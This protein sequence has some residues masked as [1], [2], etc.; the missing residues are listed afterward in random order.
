MGL[1]GVLRF[2]QQH[3][4]SKRLQVARPPVWEKSLDFPWWHLLFGLEEGLGQEVALPHGV[5]ALDQEGA[6]PREVLALD[7]EGVL[8]RE[9]E[10]LDQ[11]VASP[12]VEVVLDQEVASP[13]VEV[14]LDQEGVSPR[15]VLV[16]EV[17]LLHEVVLPA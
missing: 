4:Q 13:H 11:E 16:Q 15:E 12:R 14:V 3:Y 6:S 2:I 1:V 8:P 17:A 9:E 7:Q 10:V 5:L